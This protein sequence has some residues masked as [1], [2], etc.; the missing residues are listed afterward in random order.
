MKR[1]L[2]SKFEFRI[3]KFAIRIS[4][5]FQISRIVLKIEIR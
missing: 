3:S 5:S 2:I 1:K 4:K